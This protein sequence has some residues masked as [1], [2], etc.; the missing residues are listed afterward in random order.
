MR[1]VADPASHG[2]ALFLEAISRNGS[3]LKR[4]KLDPALDLLH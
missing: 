3:A 2:F 1:R 4:V